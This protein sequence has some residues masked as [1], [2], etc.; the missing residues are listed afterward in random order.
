MGFGESKVKLKGQFQIEQWENMDPIRWM[1]VCKGTKKV[2]PALRH[3]GV[4]QFVLYFT[5]CNEREQRDIHGNIC[6]WTW[7]IQMKIF[8]DKMMDE[9][10]NKL[11]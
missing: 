4:K 3:Q 6:W 1:Q 9:D 8:D 11:L 5:F 10:F 7:W 2:K